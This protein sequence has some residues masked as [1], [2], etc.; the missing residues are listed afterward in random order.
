MTSPSRFAYG[1]ARVRAMK[2]RL[3]GPAAAAPARRRP[4]AVRAAAA[5][6]PDRFRELVAGYATVLRCY[7]TGVALVRSLLRL[8]EIENLK[9][10]WR[11]LAHSVSPA[12]WMP[13]WRPLGTLGSLDPEA[14]RG[15]SLPEGYRRGLLAG[16]PDAGGAEPLAAELAWDRWGSEEILRAARG[17]PAREEGARRIAHALVRER[18]LQIVRRGVSRYGLTAGAAAASTALAAEELGE[19]AVEDLAR[20]NPREGP[21]RRELARKLGLRGATPADWPALELALRRSRRDL[22]RRAFRADPFCLAPAVAYLTLKEEEI[23]GLRAVA[24]AETAAGEGDVLRLVL[25]AGPLE[26]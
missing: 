14:F 19:A 18:D 15:R 3:R 6:A 4:G 10:G 8:H 2:S 16:A 24:E 1:N 7:P 13:L 20:W 17:L 26:S 5:E 9:L 12:R 11:A 25:A 22:C 23:R 21:L